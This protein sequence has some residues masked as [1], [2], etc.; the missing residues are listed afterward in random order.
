MLQEGALPNMDWRFPRDMTSVK[1]NFYFVEPAISHPFSP[2]LSSFINQPTSPTQTSPS[3]SSIQSFESRALSY[4]FLRPQ[5]ELPK[6]AFRY[7][8]FSFT[9]GHTTIYLSSAS[10]CLLP[11]TISPKPSLGLQSK[12]KQ[13]LTRFLP[14]LLKVV[15]CILGTLPMLLLRGSSP[16]SSQAMMCKSNIDSSLFVLQSPGLPH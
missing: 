7:L 8:S 6:A 11:L 15:G 5:Q 12:T 4:P 1:A 3:S 9:S 13:P 16:L 2:F 14:V 10:T